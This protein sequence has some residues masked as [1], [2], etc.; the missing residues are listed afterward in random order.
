MNYARRFVLGWSSKSAC[1]RQKA[2]FQ[3]HVAECFCDMITT[4]TFIV[5]EYAEQGKRVKF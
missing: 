1:C 3:Q 5:T 4:S 2:M